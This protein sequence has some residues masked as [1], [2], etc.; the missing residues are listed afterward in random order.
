[1]GDDDV[2]VRQRE[3]RKRTSDRSTNGLRKPLSEWDS[4]RLPLATSYLL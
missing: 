1:M 2:S 4:N 3:W